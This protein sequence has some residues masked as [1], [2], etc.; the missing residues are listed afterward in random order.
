L[1]EPIKRKAEK[2][3][4]LLASNP[5]HP[6]LRIKKVKGETIKGFENVFEGRITRDYRLFF[7]IGTDVYIL[8]CCGDHEDYLK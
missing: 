4:R 8:L 1:P 5:H 3:L 2:A 7:L 6:S